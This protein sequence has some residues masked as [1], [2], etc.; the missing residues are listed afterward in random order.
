MSA[1]SPG[2]GPLRL[3][4][5]ET[6]LYQQHHQQLEQRIRRLVRTDEDTVRDACAQAWIIF[7]RAQPRRDT[8]L[9]WLTTVA[10]REAWR[11]HAAR[12]LHA[13][14]DPMFDWGTV[15][16]P[17]AGAGLG[18]VPRVGEPGIDPF[19]VR[20]EL[21]EA[22]ETVAELPP[23]QAT[24]L[25]RRALGDTNRQV[26]ELTGDS[27]RTIDRLY[28]RGR[29]NL[30]DLLEQRRQQERPDRSPLVA[31]LLEVEQHPPRYLVNAIGRPP[32]N[33]RV[34]AG[35][36]RRRAWRRAAATIERY[37]DTHQ[38]TDPARALGRPPQD[39]APARAWRD[40]AATVDECRRDLGRRADPPSRDL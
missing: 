3:R 7:L 38:V 37:R 23:R 6:E 4:G 29:Q 2:D 21:N 30:A 22:L 31:R 14:L 32:M 24:V 13:S 11:L 9:A 35:Q 33:P 20:A 17:E 5:D 12:Y 40:A 26:G 15:P 34:P 19:E 18:R 28:R 39:P 36:E 25:L 16:E 8:L 27:E 10:Q 1:S